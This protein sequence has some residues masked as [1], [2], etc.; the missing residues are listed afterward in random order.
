MWRILSE[1]LSLL[2]VISAGGKPPPEPRRSNGYSAASGT[3]RAPVG[4]IDWR[5]SLA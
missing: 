5:I 3:R 1:T 4:F 2:T